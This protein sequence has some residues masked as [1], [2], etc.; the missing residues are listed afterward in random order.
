MEK[1]GWNCPG[2][3]V[4]DWSGVELSGMEFSGRSYFGRNNLDGIVL[5]GTLGW[6]C[7]GWKCQGTDL[8]ARGGRRKYIMFVFVV[9]D[10][11]FYPNHLY[12]VS[13][14]NFGLY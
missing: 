2:G 10:Y 11:N 4:K 3:I 9:L 14:E 12:I 5:D 6:N 13:N 8:E 7:P 1:S